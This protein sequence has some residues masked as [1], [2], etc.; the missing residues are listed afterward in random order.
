M[1]HRLTYLRGEAKRFSDMPDDQIHNIIQE[2][3][4]ETNKLH[5]R[6]TGILVENKPQGP[7]F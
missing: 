2:E 3:I 4:M 1:Q 7:T 5:Q 6:L